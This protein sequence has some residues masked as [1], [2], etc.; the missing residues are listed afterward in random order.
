MSYL[1]ALHERKST[2][3]NESK[4]GKKASRFYILNMDIAPLNLYYDSM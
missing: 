2:K 1:A 3:I 4:I